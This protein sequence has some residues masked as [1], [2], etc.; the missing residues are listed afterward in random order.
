MIK[1][2]R[3]TT[4]TVRAAI[5]F[6]LMFIILYAGMHLGMIGAYHGGIIISVLINIGLAVSLSLVTGYLGELALGHAGFMAVGAY[7]SAII[8]LN[9]N[10]PG[11]I[12]FPVALLVGGLV[13]GLLGIIIGIPALRL[14]G[15][16]LGIITLGFGEIIRVVLNNIEITGGSKGLSKIPKYTN[17]VWAYWITTGIVII[18]FLLIK[19][20]HGRAIIAIRENEIAAESV[21]IPVAYYKTFAFAVS[22]FFA[23]IMGGVYA[24]YLTQLYPK[25][26]NFL[27]SI[28]ILVIVVL[29]GMTSLKGT[30]IAAIILGLASEYLRR[31]AEYRMLIYSVLLVAI[32]LFKNPPRHAHRQR[33]AREGIGQV[34]RGGTPARRHRLVAGP[35]DHDADRGRPV[36]GHV[37]RLRVVPR[38]GR[39]TSTGGHP[40]VPRDVLDAVP[41][42]DGLSRPRRGA[43]RDHCRTLVKG[44]TP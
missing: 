29:G 16:Y 18:I 34:V 13:S 28:E 2:F 25:K 14:K 27:Y 10:V 9:S 26:F 38:H 6:V 43:R 20:K 19:S 12:I 5:I 30:I 39:G 42:G 7:T 35:P 21:G 32:I 40:R 41:A 33:C 8:T 17:F 15:D 31:Y 11:I 37:R 24:H 4:E 36:P 23:G 44:R 22:A 3:E 1:K